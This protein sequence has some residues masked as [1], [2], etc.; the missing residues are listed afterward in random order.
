[1]TALDILGRAL[2]AP[3]PRLGGWS[4]FANSLATLLEG[5]V[6]VAAGLALARGSAVKRA[7]ATGAAVVLLLALALSASR[8][9]WIAVAVSLAAMSGHRVLVRWPAVLAGAGSAVLLAAVAST[10]AGGTP[11]WMRWTASF[12]RKTR[13]DVYGYAVALLR[14][15][16]F[17]GLG[18]GDPFTA[19][20]SK[21]S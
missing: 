5:T 19:A 12:G 18:G 7:S 1:M 13:L 4:P 10:V 14:D 17:T 11:W 9:A 16:P 21:T 15:A 6:A 8:G 20:V 2:S 3:F